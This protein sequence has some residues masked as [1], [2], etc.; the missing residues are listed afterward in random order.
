MAKRK[1]PTKPKNAATDPKAWE[2]GL[3]LC[4]IATR[5]TWK[6]KGDLKNLQ[7]SYLRAAGQLARVRDERL[8]AEMKNPRHPDIEDYALKRLGLKRAS[9]YRYLAAWDWV[10]KSHP[11]WLAPG[12]KGTI[13]DMADILDLI[14]IDKELKRSNLS[15]KKSTAL[16]N[17]Q[18]KAEAGQL[19]K[20]EL[21]KLRKQVNRNAE[22]SVKSILSDLRSLRRRAD[23]A[24]TLSDKVLSAFDALIDLVESEIPPSVAGFDR[25]GNWA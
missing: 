2:K 1:T 11:E 14:W 20:G 16:T 3:T 10:S 22:E 24:H 23:Q 7:K 13:P 19:K 17:L 4:Q 5:L 6:L 9:L 8:W 25:S 21:G 12:F 15:E 18:K